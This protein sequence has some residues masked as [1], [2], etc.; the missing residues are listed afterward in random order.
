M[1]ATRGGMTEFP[2]Y[3]VPVFDTTCAGDSFVAG[4]LYGLNHDLPLDESVRLGNAAGALCTTQ[5]SH[6]AITS[7][8]DV[9]QLMNG[10]A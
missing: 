3:C 5:I 1:L 8:S 6:R 2:P 9:R 7:L 4:F 10:R